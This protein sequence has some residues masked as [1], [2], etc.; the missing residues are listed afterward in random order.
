MAVLDE[1]CAVHF[2]LNHV[3]LWYP[4]SSVRAGYYEMLS[5]LRL[6]PSYAIFEREGLNRFAVDYGLKTLAVL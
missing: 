4:Q 5:K 1:L 2:F 3:T 6:N